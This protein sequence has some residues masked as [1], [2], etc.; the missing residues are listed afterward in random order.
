M[1]QI[2]FLSMVIVDR[3]VSYFRPSHMLMLVN[4]FMK[5]TSYISFHCLTVQLMNMVNV[6][7]GTGNNQV[8]KKYKVGLYRTAVMDER[9]LQCVVDIT[10]VGWK[11]I[12]ILCT[13]YI[14]ENTTH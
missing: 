6:K 5:M 11:V 10:R 2:Q 8:Q 14:S 1:S 3:R 13:C 7:L 4:I 12:L 9:H